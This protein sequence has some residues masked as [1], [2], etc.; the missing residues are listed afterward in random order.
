MRDGALTLPLQE[1]EDACIGFCNIQHGVCVC[2]C[3]CVCV[4]ATEMACEWTVDG[5]AARGGGGGCW[6]LSL[7]GLHS[8]GGPVPHAPYLSIVEFTLPPT[9]PPTPGNPTSSSRAARLHTWLPLITLPVDI[10]CHILPTLS[11]LRR[12]HLTEKSEKYPHHIPTSGNVVFY[13][14]VQLRTRSLFGSGMGVRR[15]C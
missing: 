13:T 3:V 6:L 12:L 11:H 2:V 4:T 5:G 1:H 10:H 7:C 14:L 15:K 8:A 9:R